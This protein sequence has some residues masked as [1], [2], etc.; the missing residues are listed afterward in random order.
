ME[1]INLIKNKKCKVKYNKQYDNLWSTTELFNNIIILNCSYNQITQLPELPNCQDLYCWN[2]KLI[3]DNL[4]DWK[5]MWKFKKFYLGLKFL[6]IWHIKTIKSI[7][8]KKCNIHEELLFS[9]DL[10]FYKLD[11]Y[12]LHF[13]KTQQK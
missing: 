13:I 3:I 4:N 9:P 2:N 5:K 10:P 7:I 6:R 11:P 8:N 1:L 12:Y